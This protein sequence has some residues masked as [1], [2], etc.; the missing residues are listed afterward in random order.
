MRYVGEMLLVIFLAAGV[1][2]VGALLYAVW[3]GG[4]Q[5]VPSRDMPIGVVLVIAYAST[6]VLPARRGSLGCVAPPKPTERL[7]AP[8]STA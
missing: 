5:I 4:G 6:V 3:I 2:L 8:I 7:S 1:G